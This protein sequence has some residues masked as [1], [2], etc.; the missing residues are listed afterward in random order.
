MPA[1][2]C[3]WP[4]GPTST[5]ISKRQKRSP[6]TRSLGD[7]LNWVMTCRP[8]SSLSSKNPPPA[9][10]PRKVGTPSTTPMA[11]WRTSSRSPSIAIPTK[12]AST[13]KAPTPG[14]TGSPTWATPAPASS[15][16]SRNRRNGLSKP[17]RTTSATKTTASPPPAT[18]WV[19][20]WR[21]A[22]HSGTTSTRTSTTAC[23]SPAKPS[24]AT[25]SRT[26]AVMT[27]RWRATRPRAGRCTMC[28]RPT[29]SPP[30]TTKA[31][32]R[33]ST[34]VAAWGRS[35]PSCRARPCPTSSRPR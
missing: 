18:A 9:K 12:S 19:A 21:R 23:P 4:T 25:T 29:T 30:T 33:A 6:H 17:S 35:P 22:S 32:G 14:A 15:P 10:S 13:S 2:A 7:M 28:A 11:N 31:C 20:A 1:S 34:S 24:V 5:R 16:R 3:A 8:V 26:W 27:P